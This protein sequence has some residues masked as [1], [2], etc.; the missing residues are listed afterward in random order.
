MDDD[1]ELEDEFDPEHER[2]IRAKW[3]M[4]GAETLAQAAASLRAYAA[5]LERLEHEGW[6]LAQPIEDDYGFLHRE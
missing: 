3:C 1:I 4:D 2:V 6:H 5:E